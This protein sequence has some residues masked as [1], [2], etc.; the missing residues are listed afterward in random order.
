MQHADQESS[1]EAQEGEE[2]LSRGLVSQLAHGSEVVEQ[3]IKLAQRLAKAAPI[4]N[5]YAKDAILK[6]MDVSLEQ[7]LRLEADLAVLLH[8]SRDREEGIR[9]F[10]NKRPPNFTGS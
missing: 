9:S 1:G 8:T 6:G 5:N 10:L 3:A 7:G 4:A 2:A